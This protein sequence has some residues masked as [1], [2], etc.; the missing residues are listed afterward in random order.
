MSAKVSAAWPPTQPDSAFPRVVQSGTSSSPSVPISEPSEPTVASLFSRMSLNNRIH[1]QPP[2]APPQASAAGVDGSAPN[3][4]PSQPAER[5][6]KTPKYRIDLQREA[7]HVFSEVKDNVRALSDSIAHLP[8]LDASTIDDTSLTENINRVEEF[9]N[10][11]GNLRWQLS[12]TRNQKSFKSVVFLVQETV[13]ELNT[14]HAIIGKAREQLTYEYN[15]RTQSNDRPDAYDTCTPRFLTLHISTKMLTFFLAS[16]FQPLLQQTKPV[17]Q[18]VAYMVVVCHVMLMFTRLGSTWIFDMT[19]TIVE[20]A[21][22]VMIRPREL[23]GEDKNMIDKFPRD[24]PSAEKQFHLEPKCVTYAACPSCNHLYPPLSSDSSPFPTYTECCNFRQYP[25]GPRCKTLLIR[26]TT[27]NHQ[28]KHVPIKPFVSFDFKDWL[29]GFLSCPGNEEK[30]DA[31]WEGITNPVP[32]VMTDIFHGSFLRSFLGPDGRHHFSVS[33]QGEGRYVF[34]MGF[35]Y[36]NP[37]GNKQAG[38]KISVGALS[39]VCLNLPP[40]E[41]YK[42]ENMFLVGVVPGPKEPGDAINEYLV[43]LVDC[44]KE[45]WENGVRFTR[46]WLCSLGRLVRCAIVAVVCDLLA[47]KKIGGFAPCNQRNFCHICT[48]QLWSEVPDDSEDRKRRHGRQRGRKCFK[49]IRVGYEDINMKSW[50]RRTN[51]KARAY[52]DASVVDSMHNLFLGLLKEHFH[53]ILGFRSK[54]D[55]RKDE[56]RQKGSAS[57]YEPIFKVVIPN[58]PANTCPEDEVENVKKLIDI[59]EQLMSKELDNMTFF[60]STKKRIV[61]KFHRLVL[62]YVVSGVSCPGF[63]EAEEIQVVPSKKKTKGARGIWK[64]PVGMPEAKKLKLTKPVIVEKLLKWWKVQTETIRQTFDAGHAITQEEM[65]VLWQDI[66]QMITP[67]WLSSIP[68]RF[69]GANGDGKL[70]ADQW[71]T[72]ATTYMP[73]TLIQMWSDS[74][75]SSKRREL[76][77]FTM[78][79]VQAVILVASH[80]TSQD[81]AGRYLSYMLSYRTR[82]KSLFPNYSAHPNHHIALHLSEYLLMFGPVHGWW[83]FPFERQIGMLERISTNYQ[84]GKQMFIWLIIKVE[85]TF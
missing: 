58:N 44:F 33:S 84:P 77:E 2:S 43:P 69:G 10:T 1:P 35:D 85:L 4:S 76:L 24:V 38:K 70:K 54:E 48:N 26:P 12:L 63:K 19:R 13:E 42:P 23:A 7:I 31:S 21:M 32:E 14:C 51:D 56:K 37:L 60:A 53:S 18:L 22:T 15:A 61:N 59:L 81:L 49:K 68:A 78:D 8:Q 16:H 71:R 52:Y 3:T 20:N 41:R 50:T 17:I 36:F 67:S 30:M 64:R 82:M 11:F 55:K 75:A 66:E 46:T 9:S 5:Q 45:L 25:Q 72:I 73:V 27:V 80:Q 74:S 79:L 6:A 34:S 28:V 83:T 39:L 62:E 65:E 40:S 57:S 47:A 29:A